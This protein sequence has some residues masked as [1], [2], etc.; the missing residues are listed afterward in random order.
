MTEANKKKRKATEA[1]ERRAEELG[2]DLATVTGTGYEGQI[3]VEDV[4]N[5]SHA[6]LASANPSP[7]KNGSENG[8]EKVAQAIRDASTQLHTDLEKLEQAVDVAE[9]PL[10]D[11]GRGIVNQYNV[12]AA[13]LAGPE[14][15]GIP[16][17][18][19]GYPDLPSFPPG[20]ET[21]FTPQP[22]PTK[23]NLPKPP[24]GYH[25]LQP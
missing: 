5:V 17:T 4:E 10:D 14:V 11:I 23:W 24:H 12:L 21:D 18:W 20:G 8:D 7:A 6:S 15:R 3:T 1:A 25:P 13:N 19:P 16:E 9:S 22:P 2:V